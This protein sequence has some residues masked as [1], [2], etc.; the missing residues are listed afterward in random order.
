MFIYLYIYLSLYLFI[1]LGRERSRTQISAENLQNLCG[2]KSAQRFSDSAF[3]RDWRGFREK[4]PPQVHN[5]RNGNV[6]FSILITGSMHF[7]TWTYFVKFKCFLLPPRDFFHI[8]FSVDLVLGLG[9]PDYFYLLLTPN[10]ECEDRSK[11]R[12]KGEINC[13]ISSEVTNIVCY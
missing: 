9:L 12:I 13:Y 3:G 1:Y 5:H 10:C 2:R 6:F 8:F 7:R 4:W 11:I